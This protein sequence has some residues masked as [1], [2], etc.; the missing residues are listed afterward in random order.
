MKINVKKIMLA[1][2]V[3]STLVLN[4]SNVYA[5]DE[6]KDSDNL[7]N[8]VNNEVHISEQLD[9]DISGYS[10]LPVN[11]EIEHYYI[12]DIIETKSKVNFRLGPS[13][14]AKRITSINKGE[15]LEVIAKT[16]N[17]WYLVMYDGVSGYL[18]GDYADSLLDRINNI[19]PDVNLSNVEILKVAYVNASGLN[20]RNGSGLENDKIGLLKK[21]ES[22]L[23][24]KEIN[25]WYL[26]LTNDGLI[27]F[28]DKNYTKEL[29]G[30]FV[31]IDISE[32][33][34]WLYDDNEVLLS[35]SIVTGKDE[36]PT[37]VGLFKIKNKET[38]RYLVGEDYYTFVNYWM[39]F[40]GGIGLHDATWRKKFGG[41]I[42]QKD[43]SHG[44]VNMPYSITDDIYEKVEKGTKVLV[45]K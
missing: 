26:I 38:N 39:P 36:T 18:C 40:D 28:V 32:Q 27:G 37:N 25:G 8:D 20:V 16:S 22:I 34:L 14:D 12:K 17:N 44:C 42:Y 3:S 24:L 10:K 15:K 23:V 33:K 6:I 29:N 19:Y 1:L 41:N 7:K 2:L 30:V 5:N 31:I 35:T 9:Y 13:I 11:E 45:Q 4:R 43:G 21:Y